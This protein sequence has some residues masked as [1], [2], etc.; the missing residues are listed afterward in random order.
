MSTARHHNEWLSLVEASGPFLSMPV[1]LKVFPQGL[2]VPHTPELSRVLRVA[3]A[4]WQET[5]QGARP[6]RAIHNQWV[7]WVLLNVLSYP[8]QA[9]LEGQALPP[10]VV[11]TLA[12]QGE[13]LRPDYALVHP[14]TAT[15][16]TKPRLLVQVYP[17]WQKLDRA[18][19]GASRFWTASPAERMMQLL[20]RADVRLGLVTN[21]EHWMLVHALPANRDEPVSYISWY[22][23]AWL[24]EPLTLRAFRSL[25]HAARFFGVPDKET[26]EGM[27]TE[28]SAN[29]QEVTDQLGYQ[30]R[31][32]VETLV[33]AFDQIDKDRNRTLLAAIPETEIYQAALTVM[34]RLVFLMSAEE[35]GMLPLGENVMY[36]RYYA[37]STLGA[38]LREVADKDSE[39][40]LETRSDAWVRLLATFRMVYAGVDSADFPLPAYGGDLFDPDRYPFLEGRAGGTSWETTQAQPLPVNNRVTLHMLDA[41]QW[42]QVRVPGSGGAEKRKLSFRALDIEQIGHVYEGLL[43]HTALR[44][45][46][47]QPLIGLKGAQYNEPE[48][49]LSELEKRHAKGEVE[50]VA[51]LKEETGRTDKVLLKD[52]QAKLEPEQLNRLRTA[53]DND[54][55]IF[56]RVQPFAGL[57]RLDS[58]AN[59][60]VIMP[61]SVF[62]T[63]GSDRR[64]TGTHYTPRSLTEPI[65]KHTLDPLVY[66][67]PAEGLPEA[68]WKLR[69]AA[70]LLALKV[71]DMAMGS[72]A[73][74]VQACRY[75]SE[76]LVEAW[77][78]D[79]S[80]TGV[81]LEDTVDAEDFALSAKE[82]EERLALAR[83]LVAERCLYGVDINP[84]AVEMAKLSLWLT[85][86]DKNRPF[87][88]LNHALRC[89]DSLLGATLPQLREMSL[90]PRKEVGG[91]RDM[92]WVEPLIKGALQ[93]ALHLRQQ[94]KRLPVNADSRT[95]EE[96]ARLQRQAEEETGLLHLAA[97]LLVAESLAGL[98]REK[99]AQEPLFLEFS[100]LAT[101]YEE[102]AQLSEA[103]Q[104]HN[105]QAFTE[106]RAKTDKL[107]RG[108]RPFHWGV[109]FPEVFAETATTDGG[110]SALVGNPPF[111]G[112]GKITG[113]LGTDYRDYLVQYLAGGKRGSA[114]LCAYFFLRAD[115]VTQKGGMAGLLA[116]NTIAQGDSRE[117]GLEQLVE[118]GWS[119]PRAVPSR[120]WP[121]TAVLEVSHV[122][123]RNAEWQNLYFLEDEIVE[124]ITSF[125]SKKASIEGKPY[126]LLSNAN[127]AFK[128]HNVY[129]M[130]FVLDNIE[131]QTLIAEKA[132][133]ADVVLPFLNGEDLNTSPIQAPSRW[134]I[135]FRDWPLEKVKTYPDCF[136]IVGE[137]VKPER[138]KNNRKE[139]RERW[140]LYGDYAK[141][142][143]K[144]IAGMERVLVLCIVN[145]H[146][147]F[148]FL[149][150]NIVFS[151]RVVVFPFDKWSYFTI[152]QSHIHYHWAWL[153]SSTMKA[154]INY[155]PS[156][157]F[158]NFPFPV[159]SA[160][161]SLEE[162]GEKYYKHR[163]EIMLRRQEGLTKTY[164]RFHSPAETASDIVELRT[165]HK[166]MDEQ[167]AAAYGWADLDLQHGF[168]QTKQ[169]LR[170]TISEEARREVLGRLLTLNHQRH[171]EEVAAG[172]HDKGKGQSKPKAAKSA[173]IAP[174]N[175]TITSNKPKKAPEPP[176]SPV[177]QTSMF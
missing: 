135:N 97:D 55:L 91:G 83:R 172:L 96:K 89:G 103:A 24:E 141:G 56:R 153:Y 100:V 104:A 95:N 152:L 155:S 112:G 143:E 42:L 128:G 164:N 74:L 25:L 148:A 122:W 39:Q 64:T 43:D 125:L 38:Q 160:M 151:H 115:A 8:P 81:N 106:L 6:D 86:L 59:Y 1:L 159:E 163:Q 132:K 80:A 120:R 137:R 41:L 29:Q 168:H 98:S 45:K 57:I 50:L 114:D 61:G 99:L 60:V 177:Q 26:P 22:A 32:A 90:A 63:Q 35:R 171:A 7:K 5:Q 78:I 136:K 119:I 113:A 3:H 133:N 13:L 33:Q 34:M 67:G 16:S 51:F 19:S 75:L 49:L 72:G 129:G 110:F 130:G 147:G 107:L 54:E 66:V 82:P 73:F 124:G 105:R 27:F 93:R 79:P 118:R 44:A 84:M 102:R 138:D 94:L 77:K 176:P 139:R 127:L 15:S 30:V 12:E 17:A 10:E 146:L 85:T 173:S 65:V 109:E 131:A 53:C 108:R 145:N 40:L 158:V 175:A 76:K 62:V 68:E 71:C 28:S 87:T 20:R 150:I 101:A 9:L 117:V 48:V 134:I 111:Q 154:D 18:Y 174:A 37:V 126:L 169:G 4:E 166:Q 92:P 142:L 58:F 46:S 2:D 47:G 140:W 144:A 70:E 14:D 88:F 123:L 52:L 170:Y 162:I 21:G 157:C 149:P 11:V 69:P 36:D 23:T 156:D 121:G 165:L 161:Q 31:R 167:V 116:T